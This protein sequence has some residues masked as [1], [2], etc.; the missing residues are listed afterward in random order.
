MIISIAI[1]NKFVQDIIDKACVFVITGVG[2]NVLYVSKTLTSAV[3]QEYYRGEVYK[4]RL[5]ITIN[6]TRRV[7]K[8]QVVHKKTASG[9]R[10]LKLYVFIEY[11]EEF[12]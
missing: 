5:R 12:L 9:K 10:C 8:N 7:Y 1:L 4:L 6:K 11:L 2:I 3:P